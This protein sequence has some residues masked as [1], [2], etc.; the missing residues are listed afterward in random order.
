MIN[1]K[2]AFLLALFAVFLFCASSMAA[3]PVEVSVG[4]GT[5]VTLK[6]R[7]ERVSISEPAIA[8]LIVVSPTELLI[9]GKKV[10][11][12][13]L[14]VW[15]KDGGRTFFDVYVTGNVGELGEKIKA[16]APDDDITAEVA[17]DTIVLKGT[18]RSEETIKKAA[19]LAG[20]YAPKVVNFLR[21]TEPQQVMLEVKVAQIDKTRLKKFGMGVLAKGNTAEGFTSRFAVPGGNVGGTAGTDVTP[22]IAG[23]TI[24]AL[25]PEI[26]IAH[27]PSGVAA[28]LRALSD[29]GYAKILAEP[30]VV[31]RSGEKG[32]FLVGSRVPVQQ[33]TGIGGSQTVSVTFEEV[34]VKV[35]FTPEVMDTGMIR[36]KIDPAEVSNIAKYVSFGGVIAP[37]IDTREVRT[38]VDLKDGDSL[39]LAGLLSDETKKNISKIPLL[40]DIPVFGAFFRASEEELTNTELAF[41]ITP[42][43]IK[44]VPA[45][46]KTPLPTDKQ[47]TPQEEREFKWIPLP[48]T[49]GAA[50]EKK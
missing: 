24:T 46:T 9:N 41:F 39:V 34:G 26:G 11:S 32:S 44:A 50:E 8:D 1:K 48:G 37:Q 17:N 33:V 7:S 45:G 21:T 38:S 14:I 40:G 43:L 29:K 16:I 31:V 25:S 42:K 27:Y 49:S 28:V 10:G 4:K 15:E 35:N 23:F 20:A 12:T 6:K 22:G 2:F 19:A 36:L 5:V 18:V 47:L 30:N 3:I 13:S